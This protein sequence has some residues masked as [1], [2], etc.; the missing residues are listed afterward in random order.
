MDPSYHEC[1]EEAGCGGRP[2]TSNGS[3]HPLRNQGMRP[4][5]YR[6]KTDSSSDLYFAPSM[7]DEVLDKVIK[8]KVKPQQNPFV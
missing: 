5:K 1:P 7:V 3:L 4:V 6:G 8:V 2:D